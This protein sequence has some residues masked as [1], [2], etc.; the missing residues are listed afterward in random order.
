VTGHAPSGGA[1]GDGGAG[2]LPAVGVL[3]ARVEAPTVLYRVT[4][5]HGGTYVRL[6]P[7]RRSGAEVVVMLIA[8]VLV[9]GGSQWI[10]P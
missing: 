1:G 7:Y 3:V 2:S 8:G 6:L 10:V 4:S 5:T 9:G